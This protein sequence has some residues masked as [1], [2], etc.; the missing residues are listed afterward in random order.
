LHQF[1][2]LRWGRQEDSQILGVI[3]LEECQSRERS[4]IPCVFTVGK[5]IQGTVLQ[6]QGGVIYVEGSICGGTART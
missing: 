4:L 3:F 6:H 1:R 2:L 5:D